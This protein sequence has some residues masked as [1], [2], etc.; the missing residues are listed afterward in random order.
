MN[1][2]KYMQNLKCRK[3]G[4]TLV[5][6]IIAM[7]V[8]II[9]MV[10]FATMMGNSFRIF[11]TGSKSYEVQSDVLYASNSLNSAVR[12]STAI[13]ILNRSKY[14][15]SLVTE[16]NIQ[17]NISNI[18]LTPNWNYIGL[19]STKT[20]IY[21]FVWDETANSHFAFELTVGDKGIQGRNVEYD[22]KLF[23]EYS[24][25]LKKIRKYKASIASLTQQQKDELKTLENKLEEQRG[26]LRFSLQG[27]LVDS[28]SQV[29]S[30]NT[31]SNHKVETIVDALNTKQVIDQTQDQEATAIAYR[32]TPISTSLGNQVKPTVALVLDFSGSMI[33]DTDACDLM[34]PDGSGGYIRLRSGSLIGNRGVIYNNGT[35]LNQDVFSETFF[36][37]PDRKPILQDFYLRDKGQSPPADIKTYYTDSEWRY[38]SD[39]TQYAYY[40]YRERSGDR[41][42]SNVV[43]SI[44]SATR[45][46][47]ILKNEYIK[48][49]DRLESIGDMNLYVVPFSANAYSQW[50]SSAGSNAEKQ[51]FMDNMKNSQPFI[52]GGGNSTKTEALA[53]VNGLKPYGGTNYADGVKKALE[54]LKNS[55]Q[56]RTYLMVLSD[57]A[58][59]TFD[60]GRYNSSYDESGVH[61]GVTYIHQVIMEMN[62][63]PNVVHLVGFSNVKADNDN[64]ERIKGYFSKVTN[65][66]Q[67]K[68]YKA[69]SSEELNKA[70]K[71]FAEDLAKD[72]WYFDGP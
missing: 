37:K 9:L 42:E 33:W 4:F 39:G 47:T 6:I 35:S 52:I 64:L 29:I 14:D 21:N 58:P 63:S 5:E 10:G 24:E 17:G 40:F 23:S 30:N 54:Y 19:N 31:Y 11:N 68:V 32:N 71:L 60:Q 59:N 53:A 69:G 45:R 16:S 50:N 20:K 49:I 43:R 72:L 22:L 12:D 27:N 13:F 46:V 44:D 34:R 62:H 57:G 66:N 7:A 26:V 56:N 70:F 61:R 41:M 36:N 28:D 25:T 65:Q 3:K 38:K 55:G 1:G 51:T 18:N 8:M 15:P 67:V 48:L 2:D